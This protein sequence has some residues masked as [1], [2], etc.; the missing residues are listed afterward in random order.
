MGIEVQPV[1]I[2]PLLVSVIWSV[3][4]TSAIVSTLTNID[5]YLSISHRIISYGR[6]YL[7]CYFASQVEGGLSDSAI[8]VK[9]KDD[10][11]QKQLSPCSFPPPSSKSENGPP[12]SPFSMK[13]LE[14]PV[15]EEMP[16][17]LFQELFDSME[18]QN[19]EIG[20]VD[21]VQDIIPQEWLE[22]FAECLSA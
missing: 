20:A 8:E 1:N 16:Q 3:N 10:M 13:K 2:W 19:F 12:L 9:S 21:A 7:L 22:T 17:A 18:S 11:G 4:Q 6:S 5:S 15:S 14:V